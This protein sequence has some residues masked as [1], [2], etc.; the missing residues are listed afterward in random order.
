MRERD[1][2]PNDQRLDLAEGRGVG[3]IQVVSS[4]DTAG[5]RDA[6]R[7][8]V[9]LH[10][11]NLHRRG[12]RSHQRPHI[13][14]APAVALDR[15]GQVERV[16]HVAGRM[17]FR[18]VER[19][20]A[21][22]LVFDLG[23]VDDGE[24][25]PRVDGLHALTHDGQRMPVTERRLAPGQRDVH[26]AGRA[27]VG[28]ARLEVGGPAALDGLLQVV[29][30]A[31]DG[32]LLV[33]RCAGDLLHPRRDDAVLAAEVF[34]AN[35]LR[36]A[37]GRRRGEIGRKPVDLALDGGLVG[38]AH[39]TGAA[40]IRRARRPWQRPSPAWRGWRTPRGSR[41]RAP[42]GSCGRVSHRPPS[43]R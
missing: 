41:L 15:R 2:L 6:D 9:R 1:A 5:H 31:P 23:A 7:R 38:E 13:I 19:V 8:L 26:G 40:R 10:V 21:V 39:R 3:Q 34:V 25:H 36:L 12:M 18:H 42:T 17:I 27:R 43:A 11:A 28:G 33:G 24:A 30:V 20:E 37:C 35:R 29:G 32:L 16:L 4:V 14:G 22:P